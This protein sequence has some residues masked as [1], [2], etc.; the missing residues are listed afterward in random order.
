[1]SSMEKEL[2][3]KSKQAERAKNYF[4]L[5]SKLT[6]ADKNIR[7]LKLKSLKTRSKKV[8]AEL[9]EVKRKRRANGSHE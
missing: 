1:M 9:A 7:Y 2:D 4:D 6:E 3:L 8:D 5:K